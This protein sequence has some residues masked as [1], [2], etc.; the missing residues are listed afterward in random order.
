MITILALP[1]FIN[2]SKEQISKMHKLSKRKKKNVVVVMMYRRQFK[3]QIMIK[4]VKVVMKII[5]YKCENKLLLH[6]ILNIFH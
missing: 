5:N 4:I 1:K 3:K 6:M 2:K